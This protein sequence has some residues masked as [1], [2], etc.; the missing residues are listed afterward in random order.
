[1]TIYD[2]PRRRRTAVPINQKRAL[3]HRLGC[4]PGHAIHV[5]CWYCDAPGE[6]HWT[7]RPNRVRIY[8]VEIEHKHHVYRGGSHH[9]DNLMLACARCNS[10]RG[11]LSVSDYWRNRRSGQ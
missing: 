1:M 9:V 5:R 10:S 4:R 7:A 3:A 6:I 11:P 8:G 2:T